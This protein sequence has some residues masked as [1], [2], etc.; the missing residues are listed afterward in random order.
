MNRKK[1]AIVILST[2]ILLILAA[3]L[4]LA[5]PALSSSHPSIGFLGIFLV[6]F[7]LPVIFFILLKRNLK[8]YMAIFYMVYFLITGLVNIFISVIME[9]G[10]EI[11]D[12]DGH[13]T[14]SSMFYDTMTLELFYIFLSFQLPIII[15]CILIRKIDSYNNEINLKYFLKNPLVYIFIVSLF[16]FPLPFLLSLLF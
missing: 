4:L 6:I 7:S 3:M 16:L 11:L 15:L 14:G 8:L 5:I 1:I 10:L 12:F 9:E 13:R 2:F